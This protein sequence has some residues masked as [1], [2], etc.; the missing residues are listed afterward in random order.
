MKTVCMSVIRVSA[1][2]TSLLTLIVTFANTFRS[3]AGL[4]EF[5]FPTVPMSIGVGC[6]WAMA[7][8]REIATISYLKSVHFFGLS[9]RISKWVFN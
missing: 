6:V 5:P 9:T 3:L 1:L 8:A 4:P 7:I 2:G